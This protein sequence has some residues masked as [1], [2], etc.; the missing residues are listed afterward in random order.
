MSLAL[1]G[2]ELSSFT[3]KRW[4]QLG[5]LGC[6]DVAVEEV[7]GTVLILAGARLDRN[8]SRLG[9]LRARS[10]HWLACRMCFLYTD[11]NGDLVRAA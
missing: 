10:S 1:F 5:P 9:S 11:G 2:S 4:K 6:K 8:R 7:A 3:W